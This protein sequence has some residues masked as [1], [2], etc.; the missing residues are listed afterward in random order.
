MVSN[1]E[2]TKTLTNV[3]IAAIIVLSTS[4]SL[5]AGIQ[6]HARSVPVPYCRIQP[7]FATVCHVSP[8]LVHPHVS[9]CRIHP[10]ATVCHVR[11]VLFHVLWD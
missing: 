6:A 4:G 5:L 10:F 7:P 8:V 2:R 3:A 9:Y 11:P 1:K